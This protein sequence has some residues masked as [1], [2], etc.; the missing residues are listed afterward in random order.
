MIKAA[1]LGVELE[2]TVFKH[3]YLISRHNG[4]T[5]KQEIT[6]QL[7]SQGWLYLVGQYFNIKS[8]T[9]CPLREYDFTHKTFTYEVV[10]NRKIINHNVGATL[11]LPK[12]GDNDP[13]GKIVGAYA[14][15]EIEGLG[16]FAEVGRLDD[17]YKAAYDAKKYK[18]KK[19]D[20]WIAE[21][22]FWDK[23]PYQMMK[24]TLIAIICKQIPIG[25]NRKM[26]EYLLSPNTIESTCIDVTGT[27]SEDESGFDESCLINY[28][29][30]VENEILLP[31]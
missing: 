19:T 18:D 10:N 21:M 28:E 31:G 4:K 27:Q 9:V 14:I 23:F 7:G 22:S 29:E 17:L 5:K 1:Q 30:G 12:D 8:Y 2:S 26:I 16:T 3:G 11:F 13:R 6:F 25:G 24:K 15:I 20:Q